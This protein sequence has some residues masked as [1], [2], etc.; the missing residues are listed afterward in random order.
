M[1]FECAILSFFILAPVSPPLIN[2]NLRNYLFYWRLLLETDP[3]ISYP[4]LLRPNW[5]YSYTMQY[6]SL[7]FVLASC[8]GTSSAFGFS[9][10]QG[11]CR[12]RTSWCLWMFVV[13]MTLLKR[14][15]HCTWVCFRC[16]WCSL[17]AGSSL[18]LNC[19]LRRCIMRAHLR[20][21]EICARPVRKH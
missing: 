21:C 3:S 12:L 10:M 8:T 19:S 9:R 1:Y 5:W 16:W 14:V 17:G 20:R 13:I 6:T 7:T 18:R 15:C 2:W 11:G 4:E